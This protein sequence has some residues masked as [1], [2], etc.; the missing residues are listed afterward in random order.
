V[1]WRDYSSGHKALSA[2]LSARTRMIKT[3]TLRKL[4][5]ECRTPHCVFA[6]AQALPSVQALSLADVTS[7]HLT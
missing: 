7:N 1:S 3:R 6:A 2:S 5:K 4:R